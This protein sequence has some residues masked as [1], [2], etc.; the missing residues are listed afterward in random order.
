MNN[1]SI[2]ISEGKI[3]FGLTKTVYIQKCTE[4]F[5]SLVPRLTII[6]KELGLA[7]PHVSPECL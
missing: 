4:Q 5:I 1:I 3:I 6:L 2:E 7:V